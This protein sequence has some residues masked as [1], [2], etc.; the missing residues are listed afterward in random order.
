MRT[1]EVVHQLHCLINKCKMHFLVPQISFKRTFC[2]YLLSATYGCRNGMSAK[3]SFTRKSLRLW[4]FAEILPKPAKSYEWGTICGRSESALCLRQVLCSTH[5]TA[6][7]GPIGL[8]TWRKAQA[9]PLHAGHISDHIACVLLAT[10]EEAQLAD[11][12]SSRSKD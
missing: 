9:I 11:D 3:R 7:C 2:I 6:V 8:I 10:A 12:V 1:H 4:L 5:R